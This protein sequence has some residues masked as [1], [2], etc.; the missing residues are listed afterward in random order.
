[1]FTATN[2]RPLQ[3]LHFAR[4]Y[5]RCSCQQLVYGL[6][7]PPDLSAATPLEDDVLFVPCGA[8]GYAYS[9]NGLLD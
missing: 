6:R 1:M 2:A 3:P 8:F 7:Q 5:Y 4:R 9:L